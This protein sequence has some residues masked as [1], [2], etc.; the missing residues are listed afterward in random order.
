MSFLSSLMLLLPMSH[1]FQEN[2]EIKSFHPLTSGY[3][4]FI[5]I[6]QQQPRHRFNWINLSFYSPLFIELILVL[7]SSVF[8]LSPLFNSLVPLN[9][10]QKYWVCIHVF[11]PA[12]AAVRRRMLIA[13]RS[14]CVVCWLASQ[15]WSWACSSG[16]GEGG[17]RLIRW[18]LFLRFPPRLPEPVVE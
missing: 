17:G 14:V 8:V 11:V 12:W 4:L 15:W 18:C 5:F 2:L 6:T 16:R 13:H 10:H 9:S 3:L 7:A 1:Q